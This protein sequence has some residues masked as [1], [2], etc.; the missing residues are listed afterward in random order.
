LIALAGG[1]HWLGLVEVLWAA[2]LAGVTVA[3]VVTARSI[4]AVV[5]D[6]VTATALGLLAGWGLLLGGTATVVLSAMDQANGTTTAQLVLGVGLVAAAGLAARADRAF[7]RDVAGVEDPVAHGGASAGR[8]PALEVTNVTFS[9]GQRQVLFGVGLTVAEGEVAALLGTNGAGKS[10]LLRLVAGLDHPSGGRIRIHGRETTFLEAEQVGARGVGLLC[11]GRMSFPGLT[12]VENLRLGCHRLRRNSSQ[13]RAAIDEALAL[14]PALAD[15][16]DQR[17][18]TLSGGE[19]QMLAL[20]RALLTRPRLLLIDELTLGLAPK[21]VEGLLAIVRRINQQG[22]TI[23]IVEQSANLALTLADHA[24]F[25]E[26]GEVRFDGPTAELL[27]RD[28]LLRPVFL[29]RR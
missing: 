29:G 24:Y 7:D 17:V 1:L 9:Y 5:A 6:G 2:A 26:R 15:R 11:G 22:T 10:T 8:R 28:D 25:L 4:M 18:G 16:R 21:V 12:V 3:A 13:V 14:F 23:L 20:A 27:R 19:Q